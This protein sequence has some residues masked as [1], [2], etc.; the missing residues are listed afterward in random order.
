MKLSHVLT[1]RFNDGNPS[2]LQ[3]GISA[4]E[5]LTTGLARTK[6]YV[7]VVASSEKRIEQCRGAIARK[8]FKTQQNELLIEDTCSSDLAIG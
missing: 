7:V 3:I 5:E 4:S 8:N 1:S 6:T 2:S